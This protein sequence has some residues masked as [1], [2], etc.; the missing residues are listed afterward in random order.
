MWTVTKLETCQFGGRIYMTDTQHKNN[1]SGCL[2]L[3]LP[4]G[5]HAATDVTG[6]GLLGHA[7]NLASAQKSSVSFKIHTLPGTYTSMHKPVHMFESSKP[8]TNQSTTLDRC[9]CTVCEA[10]L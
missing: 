10:G 6:F 1:L 9:V 5:A 7:Q 3:C 2:L 8:C 4:I